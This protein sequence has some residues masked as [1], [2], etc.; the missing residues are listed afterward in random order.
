LQICKF[1]NTPLLAAN[2]YSCIRGFFFA[3]IAQLNRLVKPILAFLPQILRISQIINW[4]KT[5]V[6]AAN[7]C[8]FNLRKIVLKALLP[9]FGIRQK[10]LQ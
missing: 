3:M 2:F 6:L 5:P 1:E 9:G 8:G 10:L 4:K 7:I